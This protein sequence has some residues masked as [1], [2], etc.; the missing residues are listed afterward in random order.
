MR[1][2]RPAGGSRAI[3]KPGAGRKRLV[4]QDATLVRNL[5]ALIEP[6]S[7]GDPESPL[8][9]TCKSLRKLARELGDQ[10][11]RVS[12]RSVA[13]MLHQLGYSLQANAKTREGASHPDRN[14]DLL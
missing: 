7:R 8:R 2:T 12:P 13:E 6:L 1:P 10:G 9:W 4:E 14:A 5:E 3:R 11:H